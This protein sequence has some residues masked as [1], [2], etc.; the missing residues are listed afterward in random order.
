MKIFARI[1]LVL[2]AILILATGIFGAFVR[3]DLFSKFILGLMAVWGFVFL[4]VSLW[5]IAEIGD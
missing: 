1:T 3:D 2:I 4:V 5:E